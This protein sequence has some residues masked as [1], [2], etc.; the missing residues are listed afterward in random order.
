MCRLESILH[1]SMLKLLLSLQ[2]VNFTAKH[3]QA[4]FPLQLYC[5]HF[6]RLK[7][8]RSNP[9]V[10]SMYIIFNE[11]NGI[12]T[13]CMDAVC[14]WNPST[15]ASH[16]SVCNRL[17]PDLPQLPF[18]QLIRISFSKETITQHVEFFCKSNLIFMCLNGRRSILKIWPCMYK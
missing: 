2:S 10:P 9:A 1:H 12:H 13:C 15:D 4:F 11:F 16:T 17:A 6:L 14:A 8:C 3:F 5:M 7:L 18:K